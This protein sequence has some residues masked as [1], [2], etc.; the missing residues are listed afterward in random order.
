MES[1]DHDGNS[2]QQ[3]QQHGT[4]IDGSYSSPCVFNYN[5]QQG[6]QQMVQGQNQNNQML[7]N[8]T[9]FGGPQGGLVNPFIQPP[10]AGIVNPFQHLH[11][12][13]QGQSSN[14]FARPASQEVDNDEE[15]EPDQMEEDESDDSG[16]EAEQE[17]DYDPLAN[18][19]EYMRVRD[20]L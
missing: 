4:P 16:L 14:P 15:F 7:S 5:P 6:Q 3:H 1:E 20:Q 10:Q 11:Q 19:E 8:Q 9:V 13:S 18:Y 12:A 17:D 2:N